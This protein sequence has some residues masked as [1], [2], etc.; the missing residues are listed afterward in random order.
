MYMYTYTYTYMYITYTYIIHTV[1]TMH[2]I[3]D[4]KSTWHRP[5]CPGGGEVV[6]PDTTGGLVAAQVVGAEADVLDHQLLPGTTI[7]EG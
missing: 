2:T 3:S 7:H 1:S 5:A 6:L 4:H